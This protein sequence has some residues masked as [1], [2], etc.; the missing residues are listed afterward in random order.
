MLSAV[1]IVL[2]LLVGF[3]GS[4]ALASVH[5]YEGLSGGVLYRSQHSLK[6]RVGQ[7]WQV[8]FFR[9]IQPAQPPTAT[10]RLV[11]FPGAVAFDHTQP[12]EVI[13]SNGETRIAPDLFAETSPG[14]NVGQYDLGAIPLPDAPNS[15]LRLTLPLQGGA[16]VLRIPAYVLQEWREL[17]RQ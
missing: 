5:Q 10:L 1:L 11:G 2:M 3:E 14:P 16:P 15:W 12:L 9:E 17:P 6:D 8:V 4:S 13:T 7:T